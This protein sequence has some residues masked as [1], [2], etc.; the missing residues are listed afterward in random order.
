MNIFEATTHI[1]ND[2]QSMIKHKRYIEAGRLQEPQPP[3]TSQDTIG[4]DILANSLFI[5]IDINIIG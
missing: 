4:N 5:G 1:T 3:K 2:N